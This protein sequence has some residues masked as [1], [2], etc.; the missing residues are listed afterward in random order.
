MNMFTHLLNLL[1]KNSVRATLK[2]SS[3]PLRF[4]SRKQAAQCMQ[5]E[6]ERLR[7]LPMEVLQ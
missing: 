1:T 3:E 6:V 2:F 7:E 4:A 5:A